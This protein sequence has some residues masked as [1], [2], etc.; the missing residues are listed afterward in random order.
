MIVEELHYRLRLDAGLF[1]KDLWIYGHSADRGRKLLFSQRR[2]FAVSTFPIVA[3]LFIQVDLEELTLD[4]L[5]LSL[6]T[7]SPGAFL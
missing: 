1:D 5:S 3:L 2:E 4:T 7:Q 6:M